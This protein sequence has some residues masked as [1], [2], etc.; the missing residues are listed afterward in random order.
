[1]IKN[2]MLAILCLTPIISF[3]ADTV[4]DE[5]IEKIRKE[6]FD[7]SQVMRSVSYLADVY[8]PRL[9][10]SRSYRQAAEWARDQLAAWGVENTRLD[11][12]NADTRGWEVK[13]FSVEMTSPGYARLSV[14]PNAWVAGTN[15]IVQGEPTLLKEI[16]P[17][18]LQSYQGKLRGKIVLLGLPKSIGV[19]SMQFF[20]RYT[21]AEL[22]QAEANNNPSPDKYLGHMSKTPVGDRMKKRHQ[23]MK[24]KRRFH[25]FF[26]NEGA[27]A[28]IQ[29]SRLP[30]GILHVSNTY[31]TRKD[32]IKPIPQFIMANEQYGRLVRMLDKGA[33]PQLK[34]HLDTEFYNEPGN[35]VNVIGEIPG[36]SPTLS[37][38]LVIIGGH[39]DSWH[40]GTGA[41]DNAAGSAV[42][43]EA[44]RILKA[45]DA[46]IKRT[47]R[48][49]LWSGEEQGYVGSQAYIDKYV[50]ELDSQG[51]QMEQP[52]ISAYFNF[53]NG[54]GK[55]RGIYLQNNEAVRSIFKTYLS[56][57]EDLGASTVAI[58]NAN[59]TDHEPFDALNV[60]AFQFIQD[61]LNYMTV[62][63]HTNL[64]VYEYVQEED[65][66]QSAV[67]V[68]ALVYHVGNR[69]EMLPRKN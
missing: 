50:G 44:M 1:M 47:I 17:E 61:P 28:L 27:A 10:G 45:V 37:E 60:P 7:N 65:L 30:H 46:K 42:M 59:G 58:Q 11:Q 67:I 8:G 4:D 68:A 24:K 31:F 32:D 54:S 52:L 53:D 34:L 19:D 21:E 22:Q 48:I 14:W 49:G 55:I 40:A 6:G 15:G 66:K 56:P 33:R 57:F 43:M 26:I 25:E 20:R 35:Q 41:G 63:H 62:T 5:I 2:M 9:Q 3:G 18:A 16:S 13:S 69:D 12:F 29:P 38:E 64:D 51:A 23:Q 36:S 39:F